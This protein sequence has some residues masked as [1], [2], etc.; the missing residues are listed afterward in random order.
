MWHHGQTR[1]DTFYRTERFTLVSLSF[2]ILQQSSTLRPTTRYP[3]QSANRIV[4]PSLPRLPLCRQLEMALNPEYSQ[5]ESCP[6]RG[7]TPLEMVLFIMWLL[8]YARIRVSPVDVPEQTNLYHMGMGMIEK[9]EIT[10][11]DANALG[12]Y[13]NLTPRRQNAFRQSVRPLALLTEYICK[14]VLTERYRRTIF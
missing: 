6:V 14:E 4:V 8:S 9:F 10:D 12:G 3:Q 13:S 7:I 2:S 5:D 11:R 1:V